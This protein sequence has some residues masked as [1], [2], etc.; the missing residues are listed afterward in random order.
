MDETK[1][2]E[3]NLGI[4]YAALSYFAW[5]IIPLYWK[6]LNH[7]P[8]L[9]ILAHRVIWSF[10]FVIVIIL[11]IRKTKQFKQELKGLINNRRT[12]I[13]IVASSL[14]VTTNWGLFIWAVNNDNIIQTSLG[15]Y[16]NPLVSVLLGVVVLKERLLFWQ[17]IA[18]IFAGIGVLI[19]TFQ[20]G[21]FPWVSILLAITF[22]LYGLTKKLTNL[23]S[24][25]G[26]TLETMVILPVAL[27]YTSYLFLSG[28]DSF[29]TTTLAGQLLL[30]GGGVATALP[31]LLFAS[32]AR[33]IPLTMVGIL[34]Y[35][36][37]SISLMIGVFVYHEEF[38]R[39][40]LITFTFIWAALVI[41][42]FSKSRFLVNLQ[43][44]VRKSKTLN[45]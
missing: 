10:V 34:Q 44:K 7:I 40:H 11:V 38:T 30:M 16:I 17:V 4:I 21:S 42:T 1:Q 45:V 32:G 36:A 39:T 9:E 13:G 35:I 12:L 18:F 27:I 28:G 20:F 6:L 5:G 31:L 19:L 41:Y 26:L 24:L 14:F 33:R 15:Y 23:D 2:H 22:G 37:P 29:T 8:S 25:M 43:P 3:H